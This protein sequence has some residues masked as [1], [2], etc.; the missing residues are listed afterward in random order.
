[1]VEQVDTE[2]ERSARKPISA[3]L[4]HEGSMPGLG[5]WRNALR[6]SALRLLQCRD[7]DDP[8]SDERRMNLLLEWTRKQV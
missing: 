8:P 2:E 5:E 1:V 3:I 4:R 7:I 6:C